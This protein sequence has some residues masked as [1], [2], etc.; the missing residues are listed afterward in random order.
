MALM[1]G[2]DTLEMNPD[3]RQLTQLYTEHAMDFVRKNKKNP[4]F[5]YLP[6]AMPHVPLHPGAAFV[7][8]SKRGGYGDAIQEIDHYVGS[9]LKTQKDG[10][11]D[12]NTIVW[13]MSDN[14]PW[15]LKNQEGGSAGLFRDGKGSTW[16]RGNARAL[17]CMVA[18]LLPTGMW[19]VGT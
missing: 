6:Y 3:Q 16:R 12:G 15:V 4:F 18:K 13:F 17:Y 1:Y 19:M 10:G 5:L 14:G 7:G 8:T 11:I 2:N 9:L